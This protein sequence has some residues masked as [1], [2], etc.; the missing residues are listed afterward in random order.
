M[1][2]IL[3]FHS[4]IIPVISQTGMRRMKQQKEEDMASSQVGGSQPFEDIE[5]VSG[6]QPLPHPSDE[7]ILDI[8]LQEQSQIEAACAEE[9]EG[10]FLKN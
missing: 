9:E 5:I 3:F 4:L 10:W 7:E 8:Q 2:N 1:K 6:S